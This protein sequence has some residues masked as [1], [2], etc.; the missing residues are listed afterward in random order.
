MAPVP[1]RK[2][3]R[4]R[5]TCDFV[6]RNDFHNTSYTLRSRFYL[7]LSVDQIHRCRKYLCG[8]KGCTCGGRIGERGQQD[9]VVR[10]GFDLEG[11]E[12]VTLEPLR[13]KIAAR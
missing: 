12:V 13:G 3:P 2:K 1:T 7:P 4:P 10:V 8:V 6:M 5:L 9:Y 11:R